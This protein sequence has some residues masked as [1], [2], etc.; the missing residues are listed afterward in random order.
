VRKEEYRENELDPHAY[1]KEWQKEASREVILDDT[2]PIAQLYSSCLKLNR[3]LLRVLEAKPRLSKANVRRL[4]RS[5]ESLCLWGAEFK[6]SEGNLDDIL[7]RSRRLRRSTVKLLI[8]VGRTL[9]S[10]TFADNLNGTP[11]IITGL[12]KFALLTPKETEEALLGSNIKAVL[13]EAVYRTT[14][15]RSRRTAQESSFEY[16]SS[17]SEDDSDS[18]YDEDCIEEIAA[19]LATN[20][21][22]LMDLHTAYDYPASDDD[23]KNPEKAVVEHFSSPA[24]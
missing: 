10:S 9:S 12:V 22:C 20:T 17:E 19:D 2:W 3:G 4:E 24:R 18:D 21:E 16:T 23:Y 13:E 11:L 6:V 5:Y 8:S 14:A 7:Q 1:I 15:A